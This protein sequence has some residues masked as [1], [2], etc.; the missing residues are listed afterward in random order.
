M[1]QDT[2]EQL[3]DAAERLFS[4]RGVRASSVRDITRSAGANTAA[5]NYHFGSKLGLLQAV[6]ARRLKPLNAERIAGLVLLA[7][8]PETPRLECIL[9]AFL[10][11]AFTMFRE[12]PEFMRLFAALHV[13]P[14]NMRS[15]VYRNTDSEQLVRMLRKTLPRALPEASAQEL[16]WRV[17]FIVGAM[18]IAFTGSPDIGLLSAGEVAR[19]SDPVMLE[20]LID[21]GAAG[22]SAIPAFEALALPGDSR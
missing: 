2:R 11:P 17:H 21:F 12:H 6:C 16:F 19:D 13:A 22:L 5:V 8:A 9:R 18:S 7:E 4:E 15:L 3:L 14:D 1:A 10:Q 20:R